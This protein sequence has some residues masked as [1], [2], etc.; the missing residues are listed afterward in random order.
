M[1]LIGD[2][3]DWYGDWHV[4]T[5]PASFS[6]KRRSRILSIERLE[7]RNY[8][9]G[10]PLAEPSLVLHDDILYLQGTAEYDT[11]EVAQ[12]GDQVKVSVNFLPESEHFYSIDEING[13]LPGWLR[14]TTVGIWRR[15]W[16]L[17]G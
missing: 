2:L 9:S 10:L 17:R 4:K 6:S 8:L 13:I 15:M 12:D 14:E 11:V 3:R 16:R 5:F 1:W 7:E